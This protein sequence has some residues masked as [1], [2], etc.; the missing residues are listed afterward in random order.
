MSKYIISFLLASKES[1]ST[2]NTDLFTQ[3]TRRARLQHHRFSCHYLRRP[4]YTGGDMTVMTTIHFSLLSDLKSLWA[5]ASRI[6]R[7]SQV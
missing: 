7:C 2:E 4:S 5:Q 3:A 6:A 1:Y